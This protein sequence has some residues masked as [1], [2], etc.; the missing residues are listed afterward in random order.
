MDDQYAGQDLPDQQPTTKLPDA[1]QTPTPGSGASQPGMGAWAQ[2]QPLMDTDW[3]ASQPARARSR[4][5]SG[6]GA[7]LGRLGRRNLLL[8]A[9]GGALVLLLALAGGIALAAHLNDANASAGTPSTTAAGTTGKTGHAAKGAKGI[10]TV[11]AVSGGTITA[12][13]AD[14]STVTINT[15]SKTTFSKAGQPATLGDVT[16][17]TKLRVMG[18]A[19]SDGS[20]TAKKIEIV[21]PTAAGVVTAINGNTLT[22]RTNAGTQSIVVGATTT[23]ADA[24]TRG[25]LT[26]GDIHVGSYVQAA[27]TKN[28]DGSLA[29]TSIRVGVASG[30]AA[31]PTATPSE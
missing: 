9:G 14:G 7:R 2:Q 24:Q 3:G 20:I 12:T 13:K 27:G 26:I 11:T 4:L 23:I 8:L 16:Q 29:A 19:Q 30:A 18:K 10:Y 31:T 28:S 5:G 6:L 1:G 22:V 15:T 17:G 21:V 25:S